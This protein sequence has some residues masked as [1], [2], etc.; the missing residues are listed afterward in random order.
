V[1]GPAFAIGA[2]FQAKAIAYVYAHVVAQS[3]LGWFEPLD[4]TPL[5][6][7]AETGSPGDDIRVELPAGLNAELQVKHG[8]NAGKEFEDAVRSAAA[9]WRQ[10]SGPLRVVVDQSSSLR[11]RRTFAD[12]LT[13]LRSGRDSPVPDEINE[14]RRLVGESH[15]IWMQ[16]GVVQCDVDRSD[17]GGTKLA[18]EKL[19]RVLVDPKQATVAWGTLCADGADL[20]A[21]QG[22]RDRAHLVALLKAAGIEV[23]AL[24]P[25]ARWH[26]ALDVSRLL[27]ERRQFAAVLTHLNALERELE[28][29]NAEPRVW[30]RLHA[31]RARALFH[32]YE[33]AAAIASARRALESEHA[34]IEAL[35]VLANASLE[36]D[37]MADALNYA[38]QAIEAHPDSDTAWIAMADVAAAGGQDA[39]LPPETV[40]A[41]RPYRL[42]LCRLAAAAGKWARVMEL[43]DAL[44]AEGRRENE[45]LLFRAQALHNTAEQGAPDSTN[46]RVDAARLL[47]ELL[48]NLNDPA[49]DITR[50]AL[51]IRATVYA[52]LDRD[53]EADADVATAL[54]R[55]PD[56]PDVIR[57]AAMRR[58][59]QADLTGI[60]DLLRHPVVDR[61]A[62]L[63][64]MRAQARAASDPAAARADLDN[65]L[66]LVPAAKRDEDMRV[67]AAMV[68]L[69]LKQTELGHELL[70]GLDQPMAPGQ[71]RIARGLLAVAEGRHDEA[72]AQFAAAADLRPALRGEIMSSVA[73][74]LIKAGAQQQ[75]LHILRD[76]GEAVPA[77]ALEPWVRA[78]FAEGDLPGAAEVIERGLRQD[79]AP[80]WALAHAAWLAQRRADP[81]GAYRYLDALDSRGALMVDGRV[82]LVLAL[83]QL[84]RMEETRAQL[85]A[86]RATGNLTGVQLMEIA[87]LLEMTGRINEGVALAYRAARTLPNDPDVQRAFSG[88]AMMGGRNWPSPTAV[89]PDT[90]VELRNDSGA[91]RAYSILTDEPIDPQR[92]EITVEEARARGLVGLKP[93][94][95]QIDNPGAGYLEE[96]WTVTRIAP[97]S[98][99]AGHDIAQHFHERFVNQ[100]FYVRAFQFS[101][102]AL[103]E[104][105][106]FIRS[107]E[108]NRRHVTDLLTRYRDDALPLG[109]V[110]H[111]LKVSIADLV[112]SFGR[113]PMVGQLYVEW[114]DAPGQAASRV[115]AQQAATLVVTRS[116]LATAQALGI[117]D[118]VSTT[119]ALVAPTSLLLELREELKAAERE[120]VEGRHRIVPEPGA[121]F[122][123]REISA[124]DPS[125]VARR[126]AL[127]SLLSWTEARVRRDPRPANT[128]GAPDSEREQL[129]ERFGTS[130]FDALGLVTHLSAPLY[131]DDLGLRRLLSGTASCSSLTLMDAL[132]ERGAISVEQR[133]DHVLALLLRKYVTVRPRPE[134]LLLALRRLTLTAAEVELVFDLLATPLLTLGEAAAIGASTIRG[135]REGLYRNYDTSDVTRLVLRSLRKGFTGARGPIALRRAAEP[136]LAFFPE[137][138]KQMQAACAE[139]AASAL[140]LPR[141]RLDR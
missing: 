120:V 56:E 62:D 12:A 96:R 51:V 80:S 101:E 73:F 99:A 75:G 24:G 117:L 92:R 136:K 87:T 32:L 90:H 131:A 106:P 43:S 132:V 110:A 134:L 84:G 17:D 30:Y 69:S 89:G 111:E 39:P 58:G 94:D 65:A 10:D 104:F 67:R 112:D 125:L 49:N 79:P 18:I 2:N 29:A 19:E 31:Q 126:D 141:A 140:E 59:Q 37:R 14:I 105:L 46:R 26:D 45:L 33:P 60:L 7:W 55:Y 108:D 34:G 68:A 3:R 13:R 25:N 4:D 130:S 85:D 119:Y 82:R 114:I 21:R 122:A 52:A 128:I 27:A 123:M 98:V 66:A 116:A 113:E 20:S 11:L 100:P 118:V 61:Q 1:G 103:T 97:A 115:A 63:L 72:E 42:T 5:A 95:V 127:K 38:T 6:V 40:A 8:L 28:G 129:R 137:D 133:D 53:V 138:L 36:L 64:L 74:E 78:L 35:W 50:M 44:I 102:G 88:M 23:R 83:V 47:T 109:V 76:L 86:L 54:E 22:R 139:A 15:R 48:Q 135:A 81:E 70:D 57:V 107:M 93:G 41:T 71:L 121:G 77:D 16:L 91:T 124:G 9:R